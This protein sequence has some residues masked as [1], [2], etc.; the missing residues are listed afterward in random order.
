MITK[1]QFIAFLQIQRSG[2]TNMFDAEAVAALSRGILARQDVP[3]VLANYRQYLKEWPDAKR[4]A[5]DRS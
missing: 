4:L 5:G 1:K 3:V 2:V